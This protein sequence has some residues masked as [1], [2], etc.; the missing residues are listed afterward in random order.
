MQV[1][2]Y[3][4]DENGVQRHKWRL[5]MCSTNMGLIRNYINPIIGDNYVQDVDRINKLMDL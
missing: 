3:Y 5:S 4:T 2:Y 1:V